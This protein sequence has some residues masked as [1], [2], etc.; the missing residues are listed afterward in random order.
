MLSY[1]LIS[2]IVL[3]PS[4]L[5]NCSSRS[6]S[7]TTEQAQPYYQP[8]QPSTEQET[9]STTPEYPAFQSYLYTI[10]SRFEVMPTPK[11]KVALVTG[12]NGIT[13]NALVEH[14]ICQPASEWSVNK[15]LIAFPNEERRKKESRKQV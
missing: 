11:G 3:I 2:D 5:D 15:S 13:G 6:P 9:T 14:L 10:S 4:K 8:F 7:Q 1:I 12:A